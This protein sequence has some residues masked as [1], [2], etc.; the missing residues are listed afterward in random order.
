M[1]LIREVE[2]LSGMSDE[3]VDELMDIMKSESLAS[4]TELFKKGDPADHLFILESGRLELTMPGRTQP[5]V[6]AQKPGDIVGWSSLAGRKN[7]STAVRCT[8]DSRV[9]KV[10]KN[11]MDR[12]LRSHP[13]DGLLFY[14]HLASVVGD[15]LVMCHEA[16]TE[17]HRQIGA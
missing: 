5:T 14:K 9:F 17:A 2:L 12:I 1:L 13:A 10:D 7:Y 15:R 3:L 6:V 4:G 8:E 16:L 11:Q